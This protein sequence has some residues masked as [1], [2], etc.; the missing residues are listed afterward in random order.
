[1]KKLLTLTALFALSTSAFAGFQGEMQQGGGFNG[2]NNAVTT[3]EA[4]KNAYDDTPVA[5]TGYIVKQSNYD[6]D[7]FTFK[8]LAGNTIDIDVEDEAWNGQNVTAKDKI[9]IHGKVD[10]E[11]FG[12]QIDVYNIQKH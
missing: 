9:T 1:M 7:E 3:I 8:D 12:T 10:K 4:A 5:I 11:A 6:R 2:S